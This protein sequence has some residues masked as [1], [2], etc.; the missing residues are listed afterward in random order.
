MKHN[1]IGEQLQQQLA[2]PLPDQT[3]EEITEDNI[4]ANFDRILEDILD[5]KISEAPLDAGL[6][7]NTS[8][9]LAQL[10]WL[11]SNGASDDQVRAAADAAEDA[12][13]RQL[14]GDEPDVAPWMPELEPLEIT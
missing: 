5:G 7:T 9:K 13:A 1:E 14:D 3:L 8:N 4:R 10:G 11:V 2:S 6:Y 12:L